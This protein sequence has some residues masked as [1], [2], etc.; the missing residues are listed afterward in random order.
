M[1]IK[2]YNPNLKASKGMNNLTAYIINRKRNI[3][4]FFFSNLFLKIFLHYFLYPEKNQAITRRKVKTRHVE[5]RR[6][7]TRRVEKRRIN[8][9][10]N[11]GDSEAII[12]KNNHD[13]LND[14]FN[15]ISHYVENIF[16]KELWLFI[17]TFFIIIFISW[18][19]NDKI[20]AR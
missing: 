18:Y 6:V 8:G 4:L 20:K 7:V 15:D 17:P 10:D 1:E 14:G 9:R 13:S 12:E 11:S 19:F 5:T 16:Q 2:K 3:V